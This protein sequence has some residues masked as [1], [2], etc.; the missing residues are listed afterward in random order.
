MFHQK[1]RV[2]I[3]LLLISFSSAQAYAAHFSDLTIVQQASQ[4]G[5]WTSV[6]SGTMADG[7]NAPKKPKPCAPPKQKFCKTLTTP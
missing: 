7:S 1:K 5:L 3:S 6:L 4:T 2:A